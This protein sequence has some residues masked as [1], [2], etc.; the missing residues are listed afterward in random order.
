MNQTF[1]TIA[2]LNIML[3]KLTELFPAVYLSKVTLARNSGGITRIYRVFIIII[4]LSH[5]NFNTLY[6]TPPSV[7]QQHYSKDKC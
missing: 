2:C 1:V 5:R 4:V 7:L 6:I 3:Y